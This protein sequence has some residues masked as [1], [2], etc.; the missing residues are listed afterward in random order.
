MSWGILI[1]A[2]SQFGF[3]QS[4]LNLTKFRH[5]SI[6]FC[7]AKEFKISVGEKEHTLFVPFQIWKGNDCPSKVM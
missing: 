2:Y 4:S 5:F 7:H 3:C 6:Q 1:E